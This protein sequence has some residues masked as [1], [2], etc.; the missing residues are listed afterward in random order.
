MSAEQPSKVHQ[1]IARTLAENGV[2]TMFGVMG[3]ANM[4]MVDSFIRDCGGRFIPGAHESGCAIMALGYS[5]ISGKVGVCSV[6]HGAAVTNTTTAL[7]EG[8]KA[9]IPMVLLCGDTAVED[10][11]NVQNVAQREFIVATGAGFEQLRSPRTVSEDVARVLRRAVAEKR[12]VALN[13]P[14]DFDWAD[15]EYVPVSAH[16]PE[17]RSTVMESEDL[18]NAIG[19]IAAARR[20]LILAGRGAATP[21][22]KVA[23]LRLAE[24]LEAPLATTLK[25]KDLF[26]GE[27]FNLGIFGTVSSPV[28]V[29]TIMESDCVVAFGASLN[30]YTTSLGTFVKGKRV[31]QINQEISEIGKNV[32]PDA[33]LVGDYSQV[34]DLIVHWLDE[35]EIPGSGFRSDELRRKLETE[36]NERSSV[37]DNGNGTVDF[38]YALEQLDRLLPED[39]LYVA[40]GGR[41]MRKAWNMV[42]ATDPRYFINSANYGSIGL[43]MGYA[44][45]TAAASNG[46]PT[47]LI[48]GDGG[49][50]HAA[51]TEFNTAVRNKLDLII[52]ICN[53]GAYGAE[54]IKFSDRQMDPSNCLFDW[55]D[56]APIAEALGGEGVT[57]RSSADWDD[58]E[59]AIANRK[60]PLLIDIKLDPDL[61]SF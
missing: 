49:F 6:T 52:A 57:V 9:S 25:G 60:A 31:V 35:A 29:D 48:E 39:R 38:R 53:D 34:A 27:P 22:A 58:V 16:V 15:A 28:A 56:M 46:R 41:F 51:I 12:P 2:D 42:R 3:D 19:I 11:Q 20:P 23:L 50:M 21:N 4:F 26:L 44:L 61:V 47:V 59:K 32:V 36:R 30:R 24:R 8:V 1:V 13:I 5:S 40:G 43:G 17:Y 55:P 45:G 7:I 10:R 18:D 33:G 37:Q 14:Y 54:H